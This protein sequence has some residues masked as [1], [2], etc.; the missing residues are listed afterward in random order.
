MIR[1]LCP[2]AMILLLT[3]S[4]ALAEPSPADVGPDLPPKIR[5]LLIKEMNAILGA[6]Q[7]VLGAL[8]RGQ[9]QVV[10]EQ[11]KAIHESFILKQAMTETDR[12]ALLNA[13]PQAFVERD[14]SFHA[15]SA[16]LAEAAKRRDSREQQR[17]LAELVQACVECH[18]QH[19]AGRFPGFEQMP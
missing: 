17:L 4:A 15:L 6:T 2:A 3:S 18:A 9:H 14:R 16:E 5:A 12:R 11:A 1:Y 7:T 10:A 8:V 13:V 19:A